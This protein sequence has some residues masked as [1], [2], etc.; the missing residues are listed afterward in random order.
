MNILKQ[1]FI[2][3]R[4]GARNRNIEWH[5]TFES[6]LAWW[7]DDIANRGNRSG[8]LVMARIG[9]TG[10]YHPDNVRKIT[11]NENHAE[12]HKNGLGWTVGRKH[13]D[14]TRARIS[15]GGKGRIVS[16]ETRAIMNISKK[17]VPR[18]EETRNK[19]RATLLAKQSCHIPIQ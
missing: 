10:P 5:F 13:T 1:K 16:A 6:W 18:S 4:T 3:Q 15:A 12:A 19:I 17:G 8:Q 7:G 11:C 9:D 14:E 2:T